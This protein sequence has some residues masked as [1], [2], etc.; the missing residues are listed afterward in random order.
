LKFKGF[1]LPGV[2]LPD[3]LSDSSRKKQTAS[4]CSRLPTGN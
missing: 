4:G 1:V 2:A 3:T